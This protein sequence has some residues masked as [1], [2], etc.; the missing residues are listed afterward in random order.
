MTV[1]GSIQEGL[2]GNAEILYTKSLLDGA[3]S[4]AFAASLGVGV[5]FSVVTVLLLQGSLTLLGG[6]LAFLML[7][8]VL[9]ELTAT[10][11]LLIVAI[12]LLLLDV[13]R[14][15]VANYLPALAVAVAL[16]AAHRLG[17]W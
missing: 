4:I 16:A 5:S 10:G 11:G 17:G 13:K 15:P 9:A 2:T 1:V 7:P 3:A 14:L 8:E 6:R 12:G